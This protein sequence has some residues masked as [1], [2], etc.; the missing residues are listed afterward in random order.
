M[1]TLRYVYTDI[2]ENES[3]LQSSIHVMVSN[4]VDEDSTSG[5][6]ENPTSDI[7]VASLAPPVTEEFSVIC[8]PAATVEEDLV[9][10]PT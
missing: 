7:T 8:E 6:P 9:A 3:L 4:L 5:K 1:K 10:S 2:S